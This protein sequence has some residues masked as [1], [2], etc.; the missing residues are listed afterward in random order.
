M[1][2]TKSPSPHSAPASQR[3]MIRQL[4]DSQYIEGVFAI[5]NCQ[6]GQTKG[7]K[8]YIKCLLADRSGRVPGRM[9]NASEELFSTLPTDGF[10][11]IQGQSQ[12]YQGEMQIIIQQIEKCTPTEA[13]LLDL[14]PCTQYDIE[15]MFTELSGILASLKHPAINALARMYLDDA[16]LMEKFKRAPAAMSLHHAFIGG[17]LEHTLSLLRLAGAVLPLYPQIN[18]DIVLMGLFIH[19]LGKCQELTWETGFGYSDDGQLIGH[20]ARGVI[21][22][23][24]KAEDCAAMGNKVPDAVLMVLHHIILSHHGK[25]EFGALKI[26]ATPEAILVSLLDNVDAKT[27]MAILAARGDSLKAADVGGNFT[28]KVWALETRIYRPDPTTVPDSPQT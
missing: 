25:A 22:L 7:G 21:W 4:Q 12:P 18:R 16:E 20:I 15:E 6:L 17:L 27:H 26:P 23:Q 1:P 14:L 24:R 2:P 8:P 3:I 9:W 13:E 5:Q 10:V 19:D 11:Y 28:E